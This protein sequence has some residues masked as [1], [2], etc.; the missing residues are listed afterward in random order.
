MIRRIVKRIIA[1]I[2]EELA[3]SRIRVDFRCRRGVAK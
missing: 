3:W 1:V 2:R